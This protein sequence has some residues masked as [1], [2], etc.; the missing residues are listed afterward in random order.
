MRTLA[1]VAGRLVAV[2]LLIVGGTLLVGAAILL[3][4]AALAVASILAGFQPNLG[5]IAGGAALGLLLAVV[6]VAL[7]FYGP[8]L[9]KRFNDWTGSKSD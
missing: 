6:G 7:V 4:F 8:R 2:G 9:V 3:G 5:R 1:T